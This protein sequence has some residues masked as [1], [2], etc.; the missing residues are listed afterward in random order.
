MDLRAHT[1]YRKLKALAENH[2]ASPS[3]QEKARARMEKLLAEHGPEID[4]TTEWSVDEVMSPYHVQLFV[5]SASTHGLIPVPGVKKLTVRGPAEFVHRVRDD[6]NAYAGRLH[7]VL[8]LATFSE[9]QVWSIYHDAGVPGARP[10]KPTFHI[11]LKPWVQRAQQ[12]I[13]Q[14]GAYYRRADLTLKQ[15]PPASEVA[16]PTLDFVWRKYLGGAS[17]DEVVE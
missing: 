15:L 9:L 2:A 7:D 13:H 3:E 17:F 5:H 10:D 14:I 8:M 1:L 6:Y 12:S 11:D 4:D 16:R